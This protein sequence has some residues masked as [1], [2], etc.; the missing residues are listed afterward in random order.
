MSNYSDCTNS[1]RVDFFK[2]SGKWYA[3]EAIIFSYWSKNTSIHKAFED[4]LLNSAK[5]KYIGMTAIC[6]HPYHELSH[7]LS[8]VVKE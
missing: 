8:I 6:L 5:G 2:P 1:C 4:G 3:T 7:P